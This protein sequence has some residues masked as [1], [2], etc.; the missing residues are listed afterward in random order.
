MTNVS[1]H[2]E[3]RSGV[4]N[5]RITIFSRIVD[6]F[7]DAGFC[8]RLAVALKRLGVAQVT[9]IIDRINILDELRGPQREQGVTVLPWNVTQERWEKQGV[10]EHE[11][12]DLLIEA[13]ACDPPLA[14]LQS[15]PANAK[16]IT[17]DYLATEAWADSAH[18]K[19]SPAPN[20]NHPAAK[21]RR[22]WI[23]GFSK[24]TG[25][26]LH[27]S[28]RHISEK[29]RSAW[30]AELA[31]NIGK[32]VNTDTFLILGFGYDDAP[33]TELEWIMRNTQQCNAQCCLPK[34]FQD[35]AIWRPKG[36]Q[37]SQHEF[38]EILQACDLNFVR[39][40][41]S[42]VRAHWAAA[43]PWK[44]PFVWQPYR[45]EDKAHGHKLAG[46]L[47]QMICH[48][49]LAPLQDLHWAFNGLRPAESHAG[50]TLQT[51]WADSVGHYEEVRSQLHKACLRL[52]QQDSLEAGLL[53]K[54]DRHG[55]FGRSQ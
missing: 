18:G 8:W 30:R 23:P 28:W 6:Y 36:I 7:G 32:P 50:L 21:T 19:P 13:F 45:Q 9:L 14:Y 53:R 17:L 51:A 24:S 29:E 43:G 12:C 2:C 47:N 55:S 46:W 22:W 34:G 16:W 33:W 54:L 35:F 39:G 48:S 41:D 15:L 27:G 26:L 44:V 10:P 42:F 4:A 38:D 52:A 3:P 49:G 37:Y 5:Q 40:E 25:G 31:H 11:R 20:V 1:R